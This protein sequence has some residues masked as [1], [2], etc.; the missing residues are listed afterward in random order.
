MIKFTPQ[1]FMEMDSVIHNESNDPACRGEG[2]R[3]FV[4][5][6]GHE[7][8]KVIS[9]IHGYPSE[10]PSKE[11]AIGLIK[12]ILGNRNS[13]GLLAGQEGS[14]LWSIFLHKFHPSPVVAIGPLT[15]L[16]STK[17]TGVGRLLMGSTVAK[18][19]KKP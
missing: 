6:L 2:C 10:Q 18:A 3:D 8:H 13:W 11:Y 5:G 19:R 7:A 1:I 9:S 12:M 4:E 14:V 16:P 15:I 17:G